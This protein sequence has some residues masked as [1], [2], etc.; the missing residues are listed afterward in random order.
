MALVSIHLCDGYDFLG[1]P[2]RLP[3]VQ[4]EESEAPT[5]GETDPDYKGVNP[6]YY[7]V[8]SIGKWLKG[9]S[10]E[11]GSEEE[12]L[13][14]S[15]IVLAYSAS[16]PEDH[17]AHATDEDVYKLMSSVFAKYDS[18]GALRKNV[19]EKKSKPKSDSQSD[20][21]ASDPGETEETANA[22]PDSQE[23]STEESQ[24]TYVEL[25]YKDLDKDN[26]MSCL[27]KSETGN[28]IIIYKTDPCVYCDRLI[29]ELKDKT[30]A[31]ILVVVKCYSQCTDLF[32]RRSIYSYPSWVIITNNRVTYYGN[33][34][35]TLDNF[36]RML[37][38]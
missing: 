19:A 10:T 7:Y 29:A 35:Y 17:P 37:K 34:Y 27:P 18:T 33:G 13:G 14:S 32:Y 1:K 6:K 36:K 30:E 24:L 20:V 21:V 25:E 38:E 8:V 12:F 26:P 28:Y 23:I 3:E 22:Q 11:E 31:Y 15:L 5:V 9:K 16:L 2:A 4:G